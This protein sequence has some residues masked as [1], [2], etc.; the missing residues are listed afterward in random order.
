M[1]PNYTVFLTESETGLNCISSSFSFFFYTKA[2]S[3]E[4]R[5]NIDLKM[6]VTRLVL[7]IFDVEKSSFNTDFT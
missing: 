3:G 2:Y 4:I 5:G 7:D 6:G 1:F